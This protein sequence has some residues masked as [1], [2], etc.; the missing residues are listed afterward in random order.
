MP[1][2]V[3]VWTALTEPAVAVRWFA[4]ANLALLAPEPVATAVVV[5]ALW[6]SLWGGSETLT[7]RLAAPLF[8]LGFAGLVVSRWPY[9]VPW[10][11]V[12]WS[13]AAEAPSRDPGAANLVVGLRPSSKLSGPTQKAKTM[14][15]LIDMP[16]SRSCCTALFFD[17]LTHG[18]AK[19]G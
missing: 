17:P 14:I 2:L 12:I 15:K 10:H 19:C 16:D 8:F 6:R 13:G 7:F 5:L 18:F 11:I 3:S 1:A 9:C 4:R